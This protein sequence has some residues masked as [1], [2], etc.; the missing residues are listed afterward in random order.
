MLSFSIHDT[1]GAIRSLEGPWRALERA[2]PERFTYFQSFDWCVALTS[3]H[4]GEVPLVGEPRVISLWRDGRLVLLWPGMVTTLPPGVRVLSVLGAP[5]SQYCTALRLPGPGDGALAEH[6]RAAISAHRDI[7]LVSFDLVPA[8]SILE[9]LIANWASQ[10]DAA[11]ETAYCRLDAYT[12]WADLQARLQGK[13]RRNRQRRRTK[14]AELGRL[15][16]RVV[17]SGEPDHGRLLDLAFTWKRMWLEETGRVGAGLA[18]RG[19]DAFLAALPGSRSGGGGAML[20]ALEADGRPL[21]I[22]VGFLSGGHFYSYMG[23]FDWQLRDLSPGKVAMEE[24]QR[25]LIE[26]GAHTY[27]LLG[28]PADYKASWTNATLPLRGYMKPLTLKGR[29]FGEG[30]LA[31]LRP[32]LKG[33]YARLPR[34][35]R[36]GIAAHWMRA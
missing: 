24:C 14:L 7:D 12:D 28:T 5:Y 33:T 11:N 9:V 35:L 8:G 30:W 18:I 13:Q 23:S 22:E 32:A 1:V 34:F 29:I 10:T 27:D 3:C 17:W 25:W 15:E 26:N 2:C 31:H 6:F 16:T 36:R 4:G 20:L 19:H 21:A